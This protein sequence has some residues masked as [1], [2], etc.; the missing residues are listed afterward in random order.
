MLMRTT[1]CIYIGSGKEKKSTQ[2]YYCV[3]STVWSIVQP[4]EQIGYLVD[5][6]ACRLKNLVGGTP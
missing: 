6:L 2:N 1:H 4:A 5:G 3:L